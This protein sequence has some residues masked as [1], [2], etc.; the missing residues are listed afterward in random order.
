MKGCAFCVIQIPCRCSLSTE[1]LYYAPRLI[2]CYQ[3]A[4]NFSVIHPVNLALLQE[5][6]DESKLGHIFGNS[7]FPNPVNMSIPDFKFYNHS[8]SQV[9]A[10]DQKAHLSLRKIASAVK[11]DRKIFRTLAEPLIDGQILIPQSW[12]RTSD[13]RGSSIIYIQ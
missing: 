8:I 4:D 5:F 7:F 9:L 2:D 10:N 6:F 12:P 13:I 3:S 1:S 11:S